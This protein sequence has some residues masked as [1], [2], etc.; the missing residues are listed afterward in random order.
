MNL[1]HQRVGVARRWSQPAKRRARQSAKFKSA[2][3]AAS[4]RVFHVED[5]E[6]HGS[7]RKFSCDRYNNIQLETSEQTRTS[8]RDID[9][10]YSSTMKRMFLYREICSR[11]SRE[12]PFKYVAPQAQGFSQGTLL[13]CEFGLVENVGAKPENM[14]KL[15]ADTLKSKKYV[16]DMLRALNKSLLPRETSSVIDNAKSEDYSHSQDRH[17]R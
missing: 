14:T 7:H 10:F 5:A 11:A 17:I 13:D 2:K 3:E 1:Y 12:P 16:V 4:L 15:T 9:I 8:E 6:Y